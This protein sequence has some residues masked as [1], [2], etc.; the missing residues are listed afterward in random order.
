MKRYQRPPT[1]ELKRAE[2]V[3]PLPGMVDY[4]YKDI[5]VHSGKT[6]RLKKEEKKQDQLMKLQDSA[7][8][9]PATLIPSGIDQ[10]AKQI[11][12][13]KRF[14]EGC[15]LVDNDKARRLVQLYEASTNKKKVS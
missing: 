4:R 1:D 6:E 9:K 5:R 12:G 2:E 14:M 15:R 7:L 11:G 13:L 3:L 8:E 10:F